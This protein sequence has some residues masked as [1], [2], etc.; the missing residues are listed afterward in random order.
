MLSRTGKGALVGLAVGIAGVLAS[1]TPVGLGVAEDLGLTVLFHLR[2]HRSPPPEVLVVSIDKESSDALDLAPNARKWPRSLHAAL[3]EKLARG[4]AAVIAFDLFLDDPEDPRGDR[5]FAESIRRAGNV[6]LCE[7]LQSERM[8][9]QG[10]NG[11]GRAAIEITRRIPPI[12]LFLEAAAACA[13]YPLPKSPATVCRDWTFRHTA[14]RTPTPTLPVAAF[15][16]YAL[17]AYPEFLRLLETVYPDRAR[18]LPRTAEAFV[19]ARGIPGMIQEIRTIFE[20]DRRAEARMLAAMDRSPA[21]AGDAA[22]RRT[23]RSLIHLY[24][25]GIRKF[26]NFYGPIRTIRTIP[27]YRMLRPEEKREVALPDIAGKAVFVG[28]SESR[29]LAQKDGFYTVYTKENGVDLS[30]VEIQAT[31]FA[32]LLEDMPV[33][34]LPL[35]YHVA[36]LLLWGIAAGVLAFALRPAASIPAIAGLCVLYAAVAANRFAS[37]AVWYPIVVPILFQAPL[38]LGGALAWDYVDLFRERR[39]FRRAFA[40][41]LPAGVVDDLARSFEGL[42]VAN[43]LVHGVCLATDAEQYTA[44]AEKM[45]PRELAE[46]MNRYYETVFDPVRRHGGMVS[47]VIGDAMLALWVGT[48]ENPVPLNEACQAAIEIAG[49]IRE[50]RRSLDGIGLPTRIGLHS[51]QI[52]LGNLGAGEHFEYRPV[53]DIVNTATRIEGLNKH[54][55]TRILVSREVCSQSDGFLARD[56]GKFLLAGKSRPVHVYELVNLLAQSSPQQREYCGSF[57]A[58]FRAFLRQE[59]AE[60]TARFHETLAIRENDGPSLFFWHLCARF[61]QDPPGEGW[62]G[63]VHVDTK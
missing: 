49:G 37:E 13:P 18:A 42:K 1:L 63:V 5:A 38:I 20:A 61:A 47:N 35:R 32:N 29:Q 40:Y 3:T 36:G 59:W 25:G 7:R 39:N 27:Y 48:Q 58:G 9:V 34:P 23:V 12:P 26:L 44:L 11:R 56:L 15:Q 52:L 31:S 41:Y 46:F 54:L 62:D 6:V 53:G 19:R 21:L 51:G 8:T 16:V 28:S 55:G 17:P 10:S 33:R 43:Q 50:F 2:G 24:G 45:A 30:G 22:K 14:E 57:A 4:G 60:A